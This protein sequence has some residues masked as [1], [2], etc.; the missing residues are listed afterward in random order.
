MSNP[1]PHSDLTAEIQAGRLTTQQALGRIANERDGDAR[2]FQVPCEAPG[3]GRLHPVTHSFSACLW[4]AFTGHPD[5]PGYQM[6][7]RPEASP[8][9]YPHQ[10]FCCSAE[11]LETTV[12][13]CLRDHL[14][15]ETARRAALLGAAQGEP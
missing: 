11:C 14:H 2:A 15:P 6:S 4:L 8:G 3:C 12:L 7:E 9:T 5:V 10:H 13:G 1:N